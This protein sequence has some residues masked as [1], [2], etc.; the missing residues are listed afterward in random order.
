MGASYHWR[1]RSAKFWGERVVENFPVG[2]W[3]VMLLDP[4][5]SYRGW[6]GQET[7]PHRSRED[8]YPVQGLPFLK[9]LPLADVADPAGCAAI[10]WIVDTHVDQGI[11]MMK[12][13]GFQYKTLA[14]VWRKL[15]KTGTV[16]TGMGKYT[17]KNVELAYLFT[18]GGNPKVL[19]HGVR[20]LIETTEVIDAPRREHSRKPDELYGRIERLF[21]GPYLQLFARQQR[22]G[23]TVWGNETDKFKASA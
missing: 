15:T 22:P 20:Q 11:D 2:K 14:F 12:H 10:V 17:R 23:W 5:W 18:R 21:A 8:H 6:S 16:A 4:P 3:P 7:T 19:D 1:T 13:H 9:S